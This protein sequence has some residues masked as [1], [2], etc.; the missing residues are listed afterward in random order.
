MQTS[1]RN[2]IRIL[3]AAPVVAAAA[4]LPIWLSNSSKAL[5]Q[6]Q[7]AW[8]EAG[9]TETDIRRWALSYAILAPNPHNRQPWIADLR[10]GNEITLYCDL[11]R[12]L[13]ETDPFDRQILIGHGCFLEL[14]TLA[15]AQRGW[16]ADVRLFP[17]GESA[18]SR[19]DAKPI[20]RIHFVEA[21]VQRDALFAQVLKRRSNREAFD[22]KKPVAIEHLN[23]LSEAAGGGTV[24]VRNVNDA[25]TRDKLGDILIRAYEVEMS[26]PRTLK[27][28]VDLMRVG[29]REILQ[30]R[31]GISLGGPLFEF[32]KLFGMMSRDKLMDPAGTLSRQSLDRMRKLIDT[33][34]AYTFVLTPDNSRRA[35]VEAG[36]AYVRMNLKATELGLGMHPMSQV[37]QEYAEMEKLGKEFK[38]LMGIQET[39]QVQMLARLGHAPETAPSPRRDFKEFIRI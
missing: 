25:A 21:G 17:E 26:T 31:D 28:N 4:A 15:A 16:R 20:A 3:G 39:Q 12:L 14:L 38:A 27:E 30:H 18:G 11:E 22:T 34:M 19:L 13:P 9:K 5:Q 1:R 24:S 35:Q 32:L 37:L 33:G 10:T 2:F 8:T 6:A 29:S 36:R 23:A 7:Q